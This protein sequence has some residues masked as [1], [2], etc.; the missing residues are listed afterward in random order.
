[1]LSSLQTYFKQGTNFAGLEI[2]ELQ[3]SVA[4]EF[5]LLKKKKGSLNIV[6]SK[7]LSSLEE[8]QGLLKTNVPLVLVINTSDVLIKKIEA[9]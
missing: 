7:P 8:L 2:Y 3:G 6:A 5:L 1:M 9:A 4:Y